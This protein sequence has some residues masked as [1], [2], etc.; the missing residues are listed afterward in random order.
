MSLGT[1]HLWEHIAK[2]KE[3][4]YNLRRHRCELDCRYTMGGVADISGSHCPHD[5]PCQRCCYERRIKAMEKELDPHLEELDD[6]VPSR[7][8]ILEW[9]RSQQVADD[10]S[11]LFR[12]S[13]E[14]APDVAKLLT[15]LARLN[16]D[17]YHDRPPS[18]RPE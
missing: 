6:G 14:P 13:G 2:L 1:D 11:S 3:E 10:V 5:D 7:W 4:N 12:Y 15:K 9:T 17:L 8:R 18:W 16:D